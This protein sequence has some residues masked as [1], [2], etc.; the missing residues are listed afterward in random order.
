MALGDQIKNL[1]IRRG[2]TQEALAHEF[3]ISA[4]AVSKWE[5]GTAS[6]D[7]EL[8]PQISAFFGVTMDELFALSDDTRMERIQNML[9][10]VRFLD[11]AVVASERQFLQEK[12]HREPDNPDPCA[13]LAQL[14]QHLSREHQELAEKNAKEALRRDPDNWDALN[15]LL[16]AMNGRC[17]DWNYTNHYRLID[18]Y[19]DFIRENPDNWHAYLFIL[20][21]LIDDYRLEEANY[22]CERLAVFHGSYRIPLYRGKIQWYYGNKEAAFEIWHQMQEDYPD[23]WCVWH[24]IGDFLFKSGKPQQALQYYRRALD[25]QDP[26]R[27]L[28]P[29]EA[30]AQLHEILGNIPAALE[31]LQ[32]QLRLLEGEWNLTQGECVDEVQRNIERLKRK[33]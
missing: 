15:S 4:Q 10:D 28:D 12:A 9:W 11:P 17:A 7:I 21:Q 24:N 16:H 27:Y 22:Y 30:M 32:E 31:A 1:R 20:D 26:P 6:P 25:V 3:G 5:R 18:F 19:K 29:C 2:L 23:E 14:E 13:L 33:R 8:L